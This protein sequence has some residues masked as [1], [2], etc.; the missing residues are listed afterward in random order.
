LAAASGVL[1]EM[2][3]VEFYNLCGSGT[4]VLMQNG[5]VLSTGAAYTS[6]GPLMSI[7]AFLQTGACG[8]NGENCTVVQANLTN[9]TCVGCGSAAAV[10]LFPP[11]AFSKTTGLGF[12]NGCD[13]AGIDC[14]SP[15]CPIYDVT[16]G[17][18]T[19]RCQTDNVSL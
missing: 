2:H 13:G 4:P 19:V 16:T 15:S 9:P 3:T 18:R 5:V 1:A 11:Y 6:D 8:P 17:L 12:Y 14:T 7:L 10:N